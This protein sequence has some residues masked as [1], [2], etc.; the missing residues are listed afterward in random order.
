VGTDVCLSIFMLDVTEGGF[1]GKDCSG[2]GDIGIIILGSFT[3][4]LG[5]GTAILSGPGAFET[6]IYLA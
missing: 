1:D 3:K 2:I 4:T 5:G 6:G